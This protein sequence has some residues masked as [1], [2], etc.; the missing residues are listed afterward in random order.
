MAHPATLPLREPAPDTEALIFGEC[1]LQALDP[2]LATRADA[3]GLPGRAALLRKEGLG[4][5]LRAESTLLPRLGVPLDHALVADVD[6]RIRDRPPELS[7]PAGRALDRVA[8]LT[9]ACHASGLSLSCRLPVVLAL[10]RCVCPTGC[11]VTGQEQGRLRGFPDA[12]RERVAAPARHRVLSHIRPWRLRV[13]GERTKDLGRA[14]I[15]R[16]CG[17]GRS[18]E[19]GQDALDPLTLSAAGSSSGRQEREVS[20][21]RRRARR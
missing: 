11:R 15:S 13:K 14:V 8:A 2:D 7:L 9:D 12:R 18:L 10:G 19:L 21:Q 16:T 5:G 1:I 20:A 3:L 4:V 6:P 17:T